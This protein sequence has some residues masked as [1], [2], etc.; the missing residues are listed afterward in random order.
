MYKYSNYQ[1]TVRIF[2]FILFYRFNMAITR[3]HSLSANV[4]SNPFPL[5]SMIIY[6]MASWCISTIYDQNSLD[7]SPRLRL[8]LISREFWSYIVDIHREAMVYIL[9]IY[10]YIMFEAN[11]KGIRGHINQI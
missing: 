10:I 8:G 11:I 6:T 7:I 5:L 1:Y 4:V 2:Q 9:H 3:I